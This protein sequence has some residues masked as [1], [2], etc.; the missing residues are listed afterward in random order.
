M[1][2]LTLPT[3]RPFDEK[4]AEAWAHAHGL[5]AESRRDYPRKSR[6]LYRMIA[7]LYLG[8]VSASELAE[9]RNIDIEDLP[10]DIAD[11]LG[12]KIEVG[13]LYVTPPR[14]EHPWVVAAKATCEETHRQRETLLRR[15][16]LRLR[17]LAGVMTDREASEAAGLPLAAWMLFRAA[18]DTAPIDGEYR[19]GWVLDVAT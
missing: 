17:V 9:S 7:G 4:D 5:L 11:R 19:E 2:A 1:T 15:M 8:R 16:W 12:C 3:V 6:L 18:E 13:P 10:A 14:A